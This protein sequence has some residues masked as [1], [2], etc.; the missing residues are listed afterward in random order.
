[1]LTQGLDRARTIRSAARSEVLVHWHG[2][3]LRALNP[4][5]WAGVGVVEAGTTIPESPPG[6]P[7]C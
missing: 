4:V 3:R 7:G 6:P 1:M 2:D 5:Y